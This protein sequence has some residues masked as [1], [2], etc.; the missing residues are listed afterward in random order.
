M[1]TQKRSFETLVAEAAQVADARTKTANELKDKFF[2]EV[3]PQFA[4]AIKK[5]DLEAVQFSTNKP[6]TTY[7]YYIAEPLHSYY[8]Q[9]TS[10]GELLEAEKTEWSPEGIELQY[11]LTGATREELS[12]LGTLELCEQIP[13]KLKRL[14]EIAETQTEQATSITDE[15]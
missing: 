4:E 5:L 7:D 1:N 9:L 11:H 6:V 3:L 15:L 14:I 12:F 2:Y 10:R 8:I 13:G